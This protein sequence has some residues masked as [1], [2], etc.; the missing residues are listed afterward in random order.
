[1]KSIPSL[2]R[3]MFL[4]IQ[5]ANY[6]IFY[7]NYCH[8]GSVFGGF[9]LMYVLHSS[10]WDSNHIIPLNSCTVKEQILLSDKGGGSRMLPKGL[11]PSMRGRYQQT[12][13]TMYKVY[14]RFR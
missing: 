9:Y 14:I 4:D 13:C 8:K 7:D 11:Q 10:T 1:M 3:K 2:F 5:V 6:K 12:I